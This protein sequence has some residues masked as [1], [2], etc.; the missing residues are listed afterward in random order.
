MGSGGKEV[1]DTDYLMGYCEY[2][3][4]SVG[5][6]CT[7][8]LLARTGSEMSEEKKKEVDTIKPSGHSS[9]IM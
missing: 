7:H 8:L 1:K 2:V 4:G 6:M 9:R 5:V 3:A